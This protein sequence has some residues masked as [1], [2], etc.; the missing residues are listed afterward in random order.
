MAAIT[1][2]EIDTKFLRKKPEPLQPRKLWEMVKE[3]EEKESIEYDE[4]RR[5]MLINFGENGW[6]FR[7]IISI[8]DTLPEMILKVLRYYNTGLKTNNIHITLRGEEE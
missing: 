1:L 2:P 3:M 6:V 8:E 4:S 5:T 7:G